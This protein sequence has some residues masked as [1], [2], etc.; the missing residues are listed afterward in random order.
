MRVHTVGDAPFA[1]PIRAE[2]TGYGYAH[3]WGS[4]AEPQAT[5][6][7][8]ALAEKCLRLARYLAEVAPSRLDDGGAG[9]ACEMPFV[10]DGHQAAV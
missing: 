10:A 7:P 8:D 5:A 3:R 9:F 2:V 1:T 6:L 4:S